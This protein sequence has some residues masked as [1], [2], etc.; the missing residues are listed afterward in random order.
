MAD[1]SPA[2][3]AGEDVSRAISKEEAD[4]E[5]DDT[6]SAQRMHDGT[7]SSVESS[8]EPTGTEPPTTQDAPPPQK[9]KGGRKPVRPVCLSLLL[10]LK[11]TLDR[12]SSI[13][14]FVFH[15]LVCTLCD[16]ICALCVVQSL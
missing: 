16:L 14:S 6:S 11:R 3:T 10:P 2:T 4:I 13:L 9:R 7:P 12:I 8:P 15:V 5:A 1:N